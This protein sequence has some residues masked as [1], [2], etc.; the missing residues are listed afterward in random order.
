M[1]A[2]PFFTGLS[3]GPKTTHEKSELPTLSAGYLFSNPKSFNAS[4]ED[5][6][7]HYRKPGVNREEFLN[8][9]LTVTREELKSTDLNLKL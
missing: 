8:Q 5:V 3:G 7:I 6:L 2:F 9:V 1:T 4:L